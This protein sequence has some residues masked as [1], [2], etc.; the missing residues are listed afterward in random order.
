VV[1]RC[2]EKPDADRVLKDMH[3]GPT[4]VHFLGDTTTH[5]ILRAGYYW[6]TLFKDAHAYSRRCE[7][8]RKFAGREYKVVV[9]L[10]LV[11]VE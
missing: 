11:S 7:A 4:R 1:L 9:P 5:K 2:L 6:P 3:D 8:C 10:Q